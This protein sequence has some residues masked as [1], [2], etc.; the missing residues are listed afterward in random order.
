M[1]REGS[2][3]FGD[4]RK[5][6]TFPSVSL[7]WTISNEEFMKSIDW[8]S[9]LKLRTGY[10]MTG[11]I[12]N[13]PYASLTK[14][15]YGSSYYYDKG[16]W[17]PGLVIDSNP[18]P[19]L[20]WETSKEYNIGLDISVL[21]DRLSATVDLYSKTTS[22]MLW[23]Y[24]VPVPPNLYPRTLANV[25]EM[26]NQ[27]IEVAVNATAVKTKNFEWKT[28][29]TASHNINKLLSLSNDLYQ[30]TNILDWGGVGEPISMS[31]HRLEVGKPVGNFFGF[32]SVGVNEK[33]IWL[34]KTLKQ[35]KLSLWKIKY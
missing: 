19:D 23:E 11:V 35:S 13:S 10:G 17:K 22:D 2:S 24:Q 4:N 14:Y 7:G 21:K 20:Q 12:P 8:L 18:N 34:I 29:V 28:T 32:K 30:T 25:G 3:K 6:G 33:G 9:N 15:A 1:R 5:W 27:G 16:V 31:T 26:R